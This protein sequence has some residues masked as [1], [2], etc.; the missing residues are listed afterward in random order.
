M[1]Q[2]F[3]ILTEFSKVEINK[4]H[5]DIS[6]RNFFLCRPTRPVSQTGWT[7]NHFVVGVAGMRNMV[8]VYN[9]GRTTINNTNGQYA[10]KR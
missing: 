8:N 4:Q 5:L 2:A 10:W 1:S 9:E 7:S 3:G 6:P